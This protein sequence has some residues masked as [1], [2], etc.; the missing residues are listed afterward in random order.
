[1]SRLN[2]AAAA[3]QRAIAV[4]PDFADA[5]V[6]LG[7]LLF[8]HGHVKDALPHLAR[9]VEL[10]PNSAVIHSDYASALAASGRYAEALRRDAPRSRPEPRLRA[11][12]REPRATAADGNQV[13]TYLRGK[14]TGSTSSVV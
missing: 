5:H 3:Y 10:M 1:M 8:T 6:N 13:A 9:A 2:E 4:N 14:I 7:T 12:A 11:R